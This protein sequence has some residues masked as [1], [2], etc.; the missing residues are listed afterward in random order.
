[1]D[2]DAETNSETDEV[3]LQKVAGRDE[4]AFSELYDRFAAPLF[5]L[6]RQ[7]L[8]DTHEAEDVLQDGFINLWDKSSNYDATKGKAFSWAVMIFRNKAIDRLRARGR[9]AR[10][11]EQ[12]TDES[13][14]W[15]GDSGPSADIAADEQDRASLVR[16]ALLSLPDEQRKHIELAFLKGITHHGIAEALGLPLGTVKTSIR[17]GLLRLREAMS[18]G[19]S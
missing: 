15:S 7:M 11:A 6:M 18:R 9:R 12:A 10:Q 4:R 1:M 16:R 17:R 14:L 3:L 8:G 5:N 2:S 19:A 13:D